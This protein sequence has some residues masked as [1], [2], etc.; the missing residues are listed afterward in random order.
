MI[1]R[2][3]LRIAL[4]AMLLVIHF[5]S[6]YAAELAIPLNMRGEGM[7][8]SNYRVALNLLAG[9]GFYLSVLPAAPEAAPVREFTSFA[10]P[11]LTSA[12][13]DAFLRQPWSRPVHFDLRTRTADV[14]VPAIDRPFISEGPETRILDMRVAALLWKTFGIRWSVFFRFYE[15]VSTAA[16]FL[17]FLLVRKAGG[18]WAGILALLFY[19]AVPIENQ[20]TLRGIRDISP[21]W[22]AIAGFAALFCLA[23]AFRSRAA[24]FL[25]YGM[26]GIAAAIGYGWRLDAL[27]LPPI[28]LM[29]LLADGCIQR[30]RPR[31]LAAQA[32]AFVCGVLL[33]L[34]FIRSLAPQTLTSQVGF[35]MAYYGNAER[36]NLLGLENSLKIYRC[37]VNTRVAAFYYADANHLPSGGAP[38]LTPAYGAACRAMFLRAFSFDAWHW[39]SGFPRFV[40]RAMRGTALK[41]LPLNRDYYYPEPVWP[42]WIRPLHDFV[43]DPVASILPALAVLGLAGICF[44]ARLSI[45]SASMA[46]LLPFYAAIL[47]A[48]LPEFKHTGLLALPMCVLGGLGVTTLWDRS[49]RHSHWRLGGVVA[50]SLFGLWGTASGAAYFWSLH[51]RDR[52]IAEIHR[53]TANAEPDPAANV[54]PQLFRIRRGPG[55][56]PDRAGYLLEIETGAQPGELLSRHRRE[57]TLTRLYESQHRLEPNRRQFFF[58]TSYRGALDHSPDT[59]DMNADETQSY[60]TTVLLQG[61]ARI[62]SA[63]RADLSHWRGLEASTVF[64]EDER[65]PGSPWIGKPSCRATYGPG[66]VDQD[67]LYAQERQRFLPLHDLTPDFTQPAPY[68]LAAGGHPL[69]FLY[70]LDQW[71]KTRADLHTAGQA[72]RLEIPDGAGNSWVQGAPLVSDKDVDLYVTMRYRLSKGRLALILHN[73]AVPLVYGPHAQAMREGDMWNQSVHIYLRAREPFFLVLSNESTT[74]GI[75]ADIVEL[76]L[77]AE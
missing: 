32:L 62:I 42:N 75:E 35:H 31:L 2:R 44:W 9:R 63:R 64:H 34:G 38:Y 56:Q 11:G 14:P 69:P 27:M 17:L 24:H 60:S 33:C 13:L 74:M 1:A 8:G 55:A 58:F 21:L 37:D 41:D 49:N 76:R 29:A 26:A 45:I 72:L 25:S 16:A 51:Q 19:M 12:E 66:P 68:P 65:T 40:F 48:V 7:A 18:Y 57:G 23:G 20:W 39:I 70:R 59:F 61:D 10:R 28:L 6:R 50:L 22:F 5:L 47:F 15:L 46:L 43:L 67:L 36:T 30:T 52:Q 71:G 3:H 54:L 4:V 77:R 53:F 73:G